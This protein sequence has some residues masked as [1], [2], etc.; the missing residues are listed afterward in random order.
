[1]IT[2]DTVV[3]GKTVRV[4]RIDGSPSIVQRLMEFGLFEGEPVRV[5]SRA[6]L[7]DPIEIEFANNRLSLRNAEAIGISVLPL[8]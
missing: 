8:D 7:G 3:V 2:L 1:M 4:E 5:L 6:P